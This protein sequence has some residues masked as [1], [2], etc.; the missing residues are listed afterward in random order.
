[1]RAFAKSV[2]QGYSLYRNLFIAFTTVALLVAAG[3]RDPRRVPHKII[4]PAS[5]QAMDSNDPAAVSG[6]FLESCLTLRELGQKG[7]LA[8]EDRARFN[9]AEARVMGLA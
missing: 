8:D 6:S 7:M 5:Q 4:A 9:E 2:H 1:M 3:C